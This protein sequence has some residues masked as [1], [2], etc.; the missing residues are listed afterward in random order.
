MLLL[1]LVP[2]P[3]RP[4]NTW[5]LATK[6]SLVSLVSS[7]CGGDPSTFALARMEGFRQFVF[8]TQSRPCSLKLCASTSSTRFQGQFVH[9][10]RLL[11]AILCSSI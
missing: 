7:A 5:S 9:V 4:L 6:M 11:L 8:Q 3:D 10:K 1:F 2:F